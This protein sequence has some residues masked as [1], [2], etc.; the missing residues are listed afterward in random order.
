MAETMTAP[1]TSQPDPDYIDTSLGELEV[2]GRDGDI[3]Y[4]ATDDDD[5][6]VICYRVPEGM[7]APKSIHDLPIFGWAWQGDAHDTERY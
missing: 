3:F 1:T 7:P 2:L 6:P 5:C 4:L